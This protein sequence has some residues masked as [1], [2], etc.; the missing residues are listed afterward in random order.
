MYVIIYIYVCM[1]I[2][3]I[4]S[5]VGMFI[6][7]IYDRGVIFTKVQSTEVKMLAEFR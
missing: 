2:W 6:A 4:Y 1:Y 7:D 3:N 5:M